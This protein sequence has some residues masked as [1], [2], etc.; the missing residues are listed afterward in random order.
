MELKDAIA[1]RRSVRTY[2]GEP[3]RESVFDELAAYIADIRLLHD[4]IPVDIELC[5]SGE[6]R[7]NFARSAIYRGTDFVVLRS[8]R[9]IEGFLPNVG[10]IGEQIVLWLTHKGIG[11]CWAGMARQRERPARGELP[12]IIAI[13]FGRADNAPFRRLPEESPRKKLHEVILNEI[14]RPAFLPVLD[15]GRLAPSAVNLQPVRYMTRD[16]DI[17]I[18]RRQPPVRYRAM[19]EMQQID[20]GAALANMAVMC[21]GACTIERQSE[22][23]GL[24]EGYIYEYTMRLTE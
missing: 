13:Q 3:L 15:A 20:V 2:T 22:P 24:P 21:G 17:Y 14:S 6:F 19:D 11:S 9:N 4:N 12:Y 10:F 5:D 1:A 18:L 23:P 16:D 7:K 8:A